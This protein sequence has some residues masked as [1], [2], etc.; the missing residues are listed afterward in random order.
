M[1]IFYLYDLMDKE[2]KYRQNI[3]NILKKRIKNLYENLQL[4][5]PDEKT[6]TYYYVLID[7][8]EVAKIKYGEDFK[9]YLSEN[10]ELLEFLFRLAKEKFVVCLPGE[11]F[12]GP[13]WSIRISL[14][15]LE[16][17]DY[18]KIGQAITQTLQKYYEEYK[19]NKK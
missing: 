14:A 2:K 6:N 3:H 19:K 15:N 16:V 8:A 5:E 12:A 1:A 9:K 7:I 4:P 13:K 17:E 10:V 11:G 18:I